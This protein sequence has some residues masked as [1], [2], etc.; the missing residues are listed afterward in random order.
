VGELESL[1]TLV[2]GWLERDSHEAIVT[3]FSESARGALSRLERELSDKPGKLRYAG[4]SPWEGRWRESLETFAPAAFVTAKYEAWPELWA[5]LNELGT[6]LVIAGAKARPSLRLAKRLCLLLGRPLPSL[7]LLTADEEEKAPLLK[8]FPQARVRCVG[9]SRWDRVKERLE[10]GNM[11]AR[12][13]IAG[14]AGLPR[15]WGV[16]GS[17][18]PEDLEVWGG[19]LGSVKGTIWVVPHRV[20]APSVAKISGILRRQGITF[21]LSSELRQGS[22]AGAAVIVNEMGFLSELYGSADWS[23]VGG[24]FGEGVHSTIEPAINGIPV[25]IG[26]N[27]AGKF[28]EIAE[29]TKSGQVTVVR[30]VRELG[31]WLDGIHTADM[32]A[33]RARWKEQAFGRLG[34]TAKAL[35]E[36]RTLLHR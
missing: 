27:G 22:A 25:A 23:F 30:N 28:P 15:P 26:P 9:E 14:C 2:S 33:S 24:G 6:P 1:W 8:L 5:S 3:V 32:Q 17:A 10:N 36:V 13:L 19:R 31:Q 35:E 29:L 20:D 34:A 16:L 7:V 18:W 12:E 21:V 11:R 4:Y